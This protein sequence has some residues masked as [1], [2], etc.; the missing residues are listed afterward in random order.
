[1]TLE[2]AEVLQGS[3]NLIFVIISFI[4]GFT[5]LSKYFKYKKSHFILVGLIWIGISTPWLHGAITFI[6][7]F[8]TPAII[9]TPGFITMRFI[10]GYTSIPL[11]TVLWFLVFTS[12]VYPNKRVLLVSLFGTIAGIC[13]I[14]FFIFLIFDQSSLIGVFPAPF[15]ATY[16]PFT[17][18]TLLF[19]LI[20]ALIT[21]LIF[22]GNSLKSQDPK[23]RLKGR[24][25]II[26]FLTY[27]A[28]AV[29]DSFAFFLTQPVLVVIIRVLLIFSSIEFYFGWILPDFVANL[30][31]KTK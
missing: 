10:I 21:F 8:F 2:T 3:F 5:I 27:T 1:M 6:V 4:V 9:E 16:R 31:L 12:M 18:F 25:L 20:S 17:R 7:Y 26:A 30:F 15:T 28:C 14:M 23:I 22:A 19:F 29:M 13:E 24:F 11:I